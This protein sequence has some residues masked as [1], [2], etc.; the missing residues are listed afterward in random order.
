[1]HLFPNWDRCFLT[2]SDCQPYICLEP[3]KPKNLNVTMVFLSA[4]AQY[5]LQTGQRI[6]FGISTLFN[7]VSLYC[8]IK[9]TP[10]NQAKIR[11]YLLMT[12]VIPWIFN[13]LLLLLI[14]TKH[15]RSFQNHIFQGSSD[16]Q[17]HL[18]GYPV[19][20][21]SFVSRPGW[22]MH[23]N[24]VQSGSAIAHITG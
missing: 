4:G 5:D 21:D 16:P 7:L 12:Q 19:R 18:H 23:G 11:N 24:T 8:L 10:P 2:S 20:T 14:A 3:L 13:F 1:M 6:L 17:Q 22:N 9:E 15:V